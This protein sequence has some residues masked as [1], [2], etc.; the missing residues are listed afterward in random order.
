MDTF[1]M[2]GI[3]PGTSFQIDFDIW[4]R[5]II[6]LCG[7]LLI[8]AIFRNRYKIEFVVFFLTLRWQNPAKFMPRLAQ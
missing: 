1:L 4:V 2:L 6:L 5:G 3:V 8:S 7:L